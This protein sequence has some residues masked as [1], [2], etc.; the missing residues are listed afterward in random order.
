M[1]VNGATQER[2]VVAWFKRGVTHKNKCF[3][4][5]KWHTATSAGYISPYT[6]TRN[7][8]N[9]GTHRGRRINKNTVLCIFP[10]FPISPAFTNICSPCCSASLFRHVLVAR[11][12]GK[13][14]GDESVEPWVCL[15]ERWWGV[16]SSVVWHRER[17]LHAER[18]CTVRLNTCTSVCRASCGSAETPAVC[19]PQCPPNISCSSPTSNRGSCNS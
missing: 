14:N 4:F 3:H 1:W 18:W 6:C 5:L 16:E 9:N 8:I 10:Y 13:K 12:K 7:I 17:R 11:A 19:R 2:E 15:C